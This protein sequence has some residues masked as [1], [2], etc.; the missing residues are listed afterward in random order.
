MDSRTQLEQFRC[1]KLEQKW[2]FLKP[3]IEYLYIDQDW[4]V[5]QVSEHMKTRFNFDAK[6]IA[7]NIPYVPS[8]APTV[9]IVDHSSPFPPLG[10]TPSDV[11]FELQSPDGPSSSH[12]S[13]L[14]KNNSIDRARLFLDGKFEDIVGSMSHK[15]QMTMSTWLY[16][17]W[18]FSFKTSKY[19]GRG[20]RHW[21]ADCL[22]FLRNETLNFPTPASQASPAAY[23]SPLPDGSNSAAGGSNAPMAIGPPSQLCRWSIHIE[24]TNYTALPDPV[25]EEEDFDLDDPSTYRNWSAFERENASYPEALRDAL[26]RNDFS[27][28][29]SSSL[30]V[31]VPQVL[32]KASRGQKD[33]RSESL[34]FAIMGRNLDLLR[35]QLKLVVS[36]AEA[37][38]ELDNILKSID[39]FHLAAAYLDGSKCCCLILNEIFLFYPVTR[40]LYTNQLGHTLLDSLMITILKSH[41]CC[42]P[43]ST[44]GA[45]RGT[46]RF[47]GEEIDICGRW[48]ADS[49]CIRALLSEGKHRIPLEWKHKFCHTST[50][51]VC[52]AITTVW[53]SDNPRD[54]NTSSGLFVK[55]CTHCGLK[56]QLSP[57]HVCVMVMFQLSSQGCQDE[58][59]FGMAAVLLHMLRYGADPSLKCSVDVALLL[60][61]DGLLDEH[62]SNQNCQH[63]DLDPLQ[64]AMNIF[65]KGQSL[66]ASS[67]LLGW[68]VCEEILRHAQSALQ[69][70]TAK[71]SSRVDTSWNMSDS[72]SQ[73]DSDGSG[74]Y[75]DNNSRL[76]AYCQYDLRYRPFAYDQELRLLLAVVRTE[77]A[78]YRR[79]CVGD[80]W[81][82]QY[83]D[84][85]SILAGLRTHSV[86]DIPF[87]KQNMMKPTC[88]C[89][90]FI[91]DNDE[92]IRPNV[93]WTIGIYGKATATKNS[94]QMDV[95][96]ETAS[97]TAQA[98]HE[99]QAGS[100]ARS[101]KETA[102]PHT[103]PT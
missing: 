78:S 82:S 57:L 46:R 94:G 49:E 90:M 51:A 61:H 43:E 44:D 47:P 12:S 79:I 66:L 2:E 10:S 41:T 5:C 24:K 14:Q 60:Q 103:Q 64:F 74:R 69:C 87:I 17:F 7:W 6:F 1:F 32:R 100:M 20:P 88:Q 65:Q 36:T 30:P 98:S 62:F 76:C 55:R 58:D 89:G 91:S 97:T 16:Q 9:Q 86:P 52:D 22:G 63:E 34:A 59:L 19:W 84:L 71:S 29:H 85:N 21:T 37:P 33:L 53:G 35:E 68:H 80:S 102:G 75:D 25:N 39:A 48:D 8:K 96:D 56:M 4:S 26:E 45:F 15:E 70:S 23:D 18:L 77:L 92:C 27:S 42:K 99:F 50:Q 93:A 95:V 31:A 38:N 83:I 72:S 40:S 67:A 73:N 28:V 11:S 101:S 13:T 54:I 3:Q 81:S